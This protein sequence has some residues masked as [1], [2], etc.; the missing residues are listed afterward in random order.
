MS[1]QVDAAV[2]LERRLSALEAGQNAVENLVAVSL[3][4]TATDLG[5]TISRV[6]NELSN[7]LSALE[8]RQAG[9]EAGI[10]QQ[11]GRVTRLE[12]WKT[13]TINRVK[14]EAAFIA[15]RASIRKTDLAVVAGVF[16][17]V[18]F[19]ATNWEHIKGWF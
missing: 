17:V 16:S 8:V 10:A 11:N 6:G 1:D 5:G 18:T 3:K 13:E 4:A 2:A 9:V 14:N 7:R 19:L 15:G 12:E